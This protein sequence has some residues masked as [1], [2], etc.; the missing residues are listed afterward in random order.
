MVPDFACGIVR[1]RLSLAFAGNGPARSESLVH[2]HMGE[3]GFG[4]SRPT[5]RLQMSNFHQVL[6]PG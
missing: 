2:N 6:P 1:L 5:Q 3:I 4:A